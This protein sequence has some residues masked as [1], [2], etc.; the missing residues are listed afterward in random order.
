M[1]K[2]LGS[3]TCADRNGA[4]RP[5]RHRREAR[6][7]GHRAAPVFGNRPD[8]R[9]RWSLMSCWKAPPTRGRDERADEPHR[10]RKPQSIDCVRMVHARR[11]FFDIWQADKGPAAREVLDR[12]G[13]LY[14]IEEKIR[15]TPPDHRAAVRQAEAAPQVAELR[16]PGGAAGS[17]LGQIVPGR[18]DPLCSHTL[19][20][21]VPLPLG[22]PSGDRQQHRRTGS[23]CLRVWPQDLA[24]R[25][26]RC[27][28]PNGGR[29]LH[30]H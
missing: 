1:I 20:G 15:G 28:W 21:V 2:A 16:V 5:G 7:G 25:R 22:R 29:L 23:A 13:K 4:D 3:I 24:V 9:P 8:N 12:I 17:G 10:H 26:V 14:E 30:P 19:V 18:R 27:R 11:K 6:T